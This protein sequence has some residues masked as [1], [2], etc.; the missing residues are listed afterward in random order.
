MEDRLKTVE[1]WK[2][3]LTFQADFRHDSELGVME[4]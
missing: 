2:T 3:F 1:N 4:S